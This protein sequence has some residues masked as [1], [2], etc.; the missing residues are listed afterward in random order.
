MAGS[1]KKSLHIF[2]Q[3]CGFHYI[4]LACFSLGVK[5][6]TGKKKKRKEIMCIISN[7]EKKKMYQLQL[8]DKKSF[9][10]I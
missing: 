1:G 6:K 7:Y 5:S 9:C 10:E 2:W 3:H 8:Y 4:M